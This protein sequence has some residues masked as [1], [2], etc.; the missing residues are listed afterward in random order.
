MNY[1]E[2]INNFWIAN[3][4]HKFNS[5]ETSLYFFVLDYA[6]NARWPESF[7]LPNGIVQSVYGCT[8][9]QLSRAR[10]RLCKAGLIS[11]ESGDRFNP[12]K[13]SIFAFPMDTRHVPDA[14]P[15]DTQMRAG[16]QITK[17]ADS[18]Q[19]NAVD[20]ST[21]DHDESPTRPRC[22]PDTFSTDP[23][24][25][26]KTK[27]KKTKEKSTQLPNG[28][29]S[30]RLTGES[31]ISGESVGVSKREKEIEAKDSWGEQTTSYSKDE[32]DDESRV[33]SSL[34]ARIEDDSSSTSDESPPER[35][36]ADFCAP[37]EKIRQAF[38]DLC[39]SLPAPKESA[40]WSGSRKRNVRARWKE[41]PSIEFWEDYF[42]SV[43]E[44]EFLSGR[45]TRWRADFDWLMKPSN[46]EKVLEGKYSNRG[47]RM[48][49]VLRDFVGVGL[50]GQ[51][52]IR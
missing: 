45:V 32:S 9:G 8:K 5:L 51:K 22:V 15:T 52:N 30:V 40:K 46:F 1:I 26:N 48:A 39:P 25:I 16:D 38:I 24:N 34:E 14:S 21:D 29:S 18:A 2:L 20:Q 50:D 35:R 31:P 44:S 41:Y 6:N 28:N 43:E 4:I 17:T 33:F 13:Y 11:Y 3:K 23:N 42:N 47:D 12:G 10:R 19:M 27:P 49:D 36:S 37:Y 7:V